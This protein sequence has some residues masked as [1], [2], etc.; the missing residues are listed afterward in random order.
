MKELG[1]W[2]GDKTYA[3]IW[4]NNIAAISDFKENFAQED[5][6]QVIQYKKKYLSFRSETNT[7]FLCLSFVIDSLD[8]ILKVLFDFFKDTNENEFN[9]FETNVIEV[10]NVEEAAR[11]MKEHIGENVKFSILEKS[12]YTSSI[13]EQAS[14][15][16]NNIKNQIIMG[17]KIEARDISNRDGHISFGK[18]NNNEGSSNSD[19]AKQTLSWQKWAVLAT[20]VAIVI[21]IILWLLN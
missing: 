6:K 20:I 4:N 17:D 5:V 12:L 3:S 13:E 16:S 21:S 18:D 19:I 15:I 14:T 10:K 8:K 2:S 1:I 7:D 9:N 11:G